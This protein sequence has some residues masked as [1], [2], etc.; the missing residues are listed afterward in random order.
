MTKECSEI[1][2]R[3][4]KMLEKQTKIMDRKREL[5]NILIFGHSNI[6]DVCYDLVVVAPVKNAYPQAK[7]TFV[8][9][10][11]CADIVRA[12]K[13]VD[14]VIV[15]DKHGLDRGF[16][17]AVRFIRRIRG[18]KFD[19][20]IILRG[21]TH[22]LFNIPK[23]FSWEKPG[24]DKQ[25]HIVQRYL[26]L[27]EKMGIVEPQIRF[28][29]NFT[30]REN[31][32]A[33]KLTFEAKKQGY[34]RVAGI[35]PFAA[36]KL[37]CWPRENWDRLIDILEE[38]FRT[39]VIVFGKSGESSWEKDIRENIN[40]RAENLIDKLPLSGVL[41]I[42]KQLDLFIGPDTSLIHF[43]SCLQVP[44]IGLFGPTNEIPAYPFFHRHLVVT[45][46]KPF[47]CRPCS[48]GGRRGACGVLERP[49]ECMQAISVDAVCENIA[50]A[51]KLP[52]EIIP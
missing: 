28:E 48:P 41:A 39:K 13:A 9:S 50:R 44:T 49:A 31:D 1:K 6:G 37:K 12:F 2:L 4:S 20:G 45:P 26:Q 17:G 34:L 14:E 36:W 35:M 3:T 18:R 11:K 33:A 27:L 7:I 16:F 29:F 24:L 51:L 15:Y 25:V 38:R 21:Q 32:F 22:Y 23:I 8:T 47:S 5:K 52:D 42:I 30:V 43:S 46:A 10:P 19:L 40:P